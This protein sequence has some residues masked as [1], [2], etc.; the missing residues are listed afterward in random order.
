MCWYGNDDSIDLIERVCEAVPEHI[1]A[2][3]EDGRTP[4]HLWSCNCRCIAVAACLMENGAGINAKDKKG[5]TPLMICA[6]NEKRD[7][8]ANAEEV[9][10]FLLD[11]GAGTLDKDN[12][13]SDF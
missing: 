7:K 4:L 3:D 8:E 2:K 9:I 11:N 12:Y 5:M 6:N 10:R 1:N 13:S